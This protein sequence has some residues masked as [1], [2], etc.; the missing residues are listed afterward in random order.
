MRLIAHNWLR[1][2]DLSDENNEF[3]LV[4]HADSTEVVN[5]NY[6]ESRVQHFLEG[7][8]YAVL[9]Q[10]AA[11]LNIKDLPE[12]LDKTNHK[13]LQRLHHALFEVR[14]MEGHLA[15]PDT[16]RKFP[17]R[18]G[19]L[20]SEHVTQKSVRMY[21]PV[22]PNLKTSMEDCEILLDCCQVQLLLGKL[23]QGLAHHSMTTVVGVITKYAGGRHLLAATAQCILAEAI[24]EREKRYGERTKDPTI[25]T[26]SS[27]SK[28]NH[29]M[30]VARYMT[31]KALMV[32]VALRGALHPDTLFAK[33]FTV[34]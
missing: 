33:V 27:S 25:S 15:C 20:V 5:M 13:V 19:V 6:S 29:R 7:L 22:T 18:E 10:A 32:F 4:I 28:S 16:G 14:L 34:F 26:T 2:N 1:C 30:C 8:N 31:Q 11:S 9:L 3:V 24:V 12:E 17:V 23:Q 21:T